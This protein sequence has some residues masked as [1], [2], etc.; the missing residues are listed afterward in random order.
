M[1]FFEIRRILKRVKK[2]RIGIFIL[3]VIA[4]FLLGCWG[5]WRSFAVVQGNHSVLDLCYASL[6]LFVLEIA[7]PVPMNWQLQIARFF[8]AT[9]TFYA[10]LSVVFIVCYT[11]FIRFRLMFWN[12]HAIICGLGYLG[13]VIARYYLEHGR[14]TVIIE[15]NPLNSEIESCKDMG[16]IV[17]TG[18]ATQDDVLEMANIVKASDIFAVTGNDVKNLE[19]A[20][21]A[22]SPDR[23]DQSLT[24]HIHITDMNLCSVLKSHQ[25]RSQ[26][27]SNF[28]I[29]FFNIY[30]IAGYCLQQAYPPYSEGRE[31]AP[32][33]HILV[34]G[35]GRMGKTL[36]VR[37]TK[38]WR[39]NYG[40]SGKKLIISVIDRHAD[41]VKAF[42]EARYPSLPYYCD[43]IAYP[44][45]FL[46]QEFLKGTFLIEKEN[47]PPPSSLY[48]TIKETSMGLS[49][50]LTLQEIMGNRKI[51]IIVQTINVDAFT[52]MLDELRIH[53]EILQNIHPFQ[54]ISCN[55]CKDLII[56][57]YRGLIAR[58]IH[59]TYLTKKKEC[60]TLDGNDPANR[61]WPDLN[62]LLKES[63][64]HQADFIY[65]QLLAIGCDIIPESSWDEPAFTFTPTELEY[66]AEREHERWMQER[67][68]NG[69][70]YGPA[71]DIEKK[72]S[73]YLIPYRL[74]D[75]EI[76][77]YDRNTVRA[78]PHI[79]SK[80]QF[81]I[82]RYKDFLA[83]PEE[84]SLKDE[85]GGLFRY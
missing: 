29:E 79:L 66:L 47:I 1:K 57:G 38:K 49:L 43:L 20:I 61:E 37:I 17:L 68:K 41:E 44:L 40:K 16:A 28:K 18:D 70:R 82:I 32:D 63:N 51:P 42:L 2:Y 6:Q 15:A 76:K 8:A 83:D 35:A 58:A 85:K 22:Q 84:K 25:L 30:T 53:S 24:C 10:L 31:V 11:Q 59:N 72:I 3:F 45:E 21:K 9:L 52:K 62:E 75:D 50:A 34:F 69:W 71:K 26:N 60:A 14:K 55:C 23:L 54:I 64:Y 67:I 5:F 27:M 65:S 46:S 80:I 74:L 81:K 7:E 48:I 78:L 33:T 19:I 77:D 73:P 12:K 13:P 56:S 4:A 36:I 39:D